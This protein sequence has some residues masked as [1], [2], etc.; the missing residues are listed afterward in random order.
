V[1][2]ASPLRYPGGKW[3]IAPLFRRVIEINRLDS[4]IYIE[5]Y[6][7]GASL[8]LSLLFD[9]L[10]A[11]I[12]LNDL[13]SAVYAFWCS[14]LTK[15]R[16]FLQLVH[17]VPVT[18]DEWY[19]QR[20]IYSEG[21]RSGTLA[22]GFAKF[23]LNRTSHSGILNGGMIG[24]KEQTGIWKLDARFNRPELA[25]RILRISSVKNRIF[26]MKRDALDVLKDCSVSRNT[27]I[28]LDPPYYRPGRHL[29]LND[30]KHDDHV[31][32][33]KRVAILPCPWIVSY[34]DVSEIRKLYKGIH[35]KRLALMHTASRAHQGAE[36]VYF[37]PKLRIPKSV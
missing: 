19:R 28:Y 7:G 9:G 33:R 31:A 24:G 23:F 13:D 35:C 3:R 22:L 6:S 5:P 1:R 30:Y 32:V 29:Y 34:D 12:H 25:R 15:T 18:P 37:S 11:E 16:A 21:T 27:L 36:I 4:P 10:V 2:S 20:A 8:A 26:L 17:E 14:V